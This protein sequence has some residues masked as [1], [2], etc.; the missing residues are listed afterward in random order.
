MWQCD[1]V[2]H[3]I[4]AHDRWANRPTARGGKRKTPA[5]S[6]VGRGLR[7]CVGLEAEFYLWLAHA[8]VGLG[9]DGRLILLPERLR[10]GLVL[11]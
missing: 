9:G 4:V 10:Q 7:Y 1:M 8:T 5:E 3:P 2:S 6:Q 11:V